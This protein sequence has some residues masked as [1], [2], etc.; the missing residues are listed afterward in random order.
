MA[1]EEYREPGK[2]HYH[3]DREERI[4]RLSSHIRERETEPS[5]MFK[6]GF[7]K[8][9]RSLLLI[10]IDILIIVLIAVIVIPF[11]GNTAKSTA[12]ADGYYYSLRGFVFEEKAFLSLKV[13]AQQDAP[14]RAEEVVRAIFTLEH[15]HRQV[16]TVD[17]LP[18]GKGEERL[19]RAT[20]PFSGEST[21][22]YVAI[23]HDSSE[24]TLETELTP[25]QQ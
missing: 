6:K 18:I 15:S 9:N 20:I 10:L 4:R 8:R 1:K 14:E 25:E 13:E 11:V 12:S 21:T 16:E 3:Y 19:I 24:I 17:V 7:F 23:R 2:Y 22:A 5:G